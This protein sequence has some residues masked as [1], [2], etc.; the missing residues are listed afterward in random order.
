MGIIK[1]IECANCGKEMTA[2]IRNTFIRV[3]PCHC[4]PKKYGFFRRLYANLR[5]RM[6]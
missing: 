3:F 6:P 5:A 2:E 1:W 4:A